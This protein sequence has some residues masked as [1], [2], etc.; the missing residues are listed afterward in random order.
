MDFHS[1]DS[2]TGSKKLV[3]CCSFSPWVFST[4]MV[5]MLQVWLLLQGQKNL[6]VPWKN[7]EV[8]D[9]A[10]M[11]LSSEQQELA[12]GLKHGTAG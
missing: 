1:Q 7:L 12:K 9:S 6:E 5:E 3:D 10:E 11:F 4:D 2:Q 8:Q